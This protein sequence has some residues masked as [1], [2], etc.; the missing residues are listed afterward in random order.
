MT[1]DKHDK[2][3]I[4]ATGII[5]VALYFWLK[6]GGSMPTALNL[7]NLFAPANL[8]QPSTN[9]PFWLQNNNYP[10]GNGGFTLPLPTLT[11]GGCEVCSLFPSP[12][13][14]IGFNTL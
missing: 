3:A 6:N 12:Q 13:P 5:L 11:G 8:P 10:Q 4:G 1:L 9:V 14:A 2:I 7:A